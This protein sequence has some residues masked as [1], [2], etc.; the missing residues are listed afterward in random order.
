MK[1][2]FFNK[3]MEENGIIYR[4]IYLERLVSLYENEKSNIYFCT[5]TRL[6]YATKY[7]RQNGEV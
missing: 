4:I 7:W 5:M 2:P 6:R 1:K 3:I